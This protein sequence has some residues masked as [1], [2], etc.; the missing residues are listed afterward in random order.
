[1]YDR[2]LHRA[3]VGRKLGKLAFAAR[4]F[5]GPRHRMYFR[6]A[7]MSGRARDIGV[8]W[9]NG[10]HHTDERPTRT[11]VTRWLREILFGASVS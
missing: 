10:A 6:M 1:A 4:H 9:Y 2:A 8:D 3:P 7:R 11:L 5:Y